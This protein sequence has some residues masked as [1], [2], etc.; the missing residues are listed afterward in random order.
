MEEKAGRKERKKEVVEVRRGHLPT[1]P[2]AT[3]PRGQP[4][5]DP[6]HQVALPR[7]PPRPLAIG[8]DDGWRHWASLTPPS[9]GPR[10]RRRTAQRRKKKKLPKTAR[11]RMKGTRK[12]GRGG[13]EAGGGGGD[14]GK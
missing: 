2:P 1:G 5:R 9:P 11:R 10:R 8:G 4:F 6:A 13:T 12:V 7:A 14:T 3:F